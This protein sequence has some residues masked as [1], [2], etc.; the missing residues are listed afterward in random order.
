MHNIK[1]PSTLETIGKEAF[2][3]CSNLEEMIVPE[4]TTTIIVTVYCDEGSE[5]QAYCKRNG[6]HE[7]RITDKEND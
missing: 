5:I 4:K 1:L 7:E 3:R 6:I 2:R